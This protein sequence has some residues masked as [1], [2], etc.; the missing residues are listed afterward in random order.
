MVSKITYEKFQMEGTGL[1]Q[2]GVLVNLDSGKNAFVVIN[3]QK[4]PFGIG[5]SNNALKPWVSVAS[6]NIDIGTKLYI[7]ALDGLQLP[8]GK[9]HNGC[10]RVD[11]VGWNLEECQVD[12]FVLL[13]SD[14]RALVSKLP[15]STAVEKKR[16][17][18][19]TYVTYNS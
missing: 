15:D 7:K 5:S 11:D 13:Y 17:T 2:D 9:T 4:A 3:R 6:N 14:Y 19:K 18:L 12:L 8:N 16:C 1:L 10:V